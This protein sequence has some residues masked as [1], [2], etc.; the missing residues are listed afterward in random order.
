MRAS[1][2]SQVVEKIKALPSEDKLYLKTLLEKMLIEEK[3]K[4][5]KENAEISFK[6][7]KEGKTKKG[8]IAELKKDLYG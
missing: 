7:H 2:F 5:I 3:R 6:E 8:G 1:T 4:K